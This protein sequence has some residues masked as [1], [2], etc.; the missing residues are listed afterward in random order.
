VNFSVFTAACDLRIPE[1]HKLY[2]FIFLAV[3]QMLNLLE[4]IK[5]TEITAVQLE[6]TRNVDYGIQC[7]ELI[8][9][10]IGVRIR[11]SYSAIMDP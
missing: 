5:K 7:H 4:G 1:P 8:T 3:I 10:S 11:I 9:L 2:L 6:Y